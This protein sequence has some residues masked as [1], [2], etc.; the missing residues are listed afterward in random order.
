[1]TSRKPLQFQKY[2]GLTEYLLGS[3][4]LDYIRSELKLAG[5]FGRKLLEILP[6]STG[7]TVTYL[8]QDINPNFIN[9]YRDSCGETNQPIYS[10]TH[11][12]ANSFVKQ[13][14]VRSEQSLVIFN[15]LAHATDPWLQRFHAQFIIYKDE[16]YLYYTKRDQSEIMEEKR[17]R[18]KGSYPG[19]TVLTTIPPGLTI[20]NGQSISTK[21][22]MLMVTQTES[23]LVEAYDEDGFILWIKQ[24]S[25]YANKSYEL[26]E[27]IIKEAGVND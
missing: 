7:R 15:T 24:P 16:V 27:R 5:D 6:L 12:L 1:M 25:T 21:Q 18:G 2:F 19:I 26:P 10:N 4:A 13:H 11:R 17:L 8:P 14:L 22:L 20:N 9:D 3:E 23:L